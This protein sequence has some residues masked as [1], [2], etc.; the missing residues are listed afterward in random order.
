MMLIDEA[1]IYVSS[2]KGGDG[3][4]HFHREKYVAR[5][6]PDGGDGGRGGDVF[7]EAVPTLNTLASFRYQTRFVAKDGRNGG[8]NNMTGRSADPLVILVPPGTIVY[9]E[10]GALLGDLTQPGQRLRVAAG[11]RG[12]VAIPLC[13][14]QQPGAPLARRASLGGTHA[15]PGTG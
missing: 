14:L 6:G 7:L 2:G 5:G 9:D 3:M 12:G 15:A 13:H 8:V 10:Q 11:G 1:T 4:V